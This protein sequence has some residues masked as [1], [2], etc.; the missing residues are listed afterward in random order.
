MPRVTLHTSS[1]VKR[2]KV[3]V[4]RW[5]NDLDDSSGHHL[6]GAWAYWGGL[7]HSWKTKSV[8]ARLNALLIRNI[9]FSASESSQHLWIY[10]IM[11]LYKFKYYYYYYYYYQCPSLFWHYCL[12]DRKCI[13]IVKHTAQSPEFLLWSNKNNSP[14]KRKTEVSQPVS[15]CVITVC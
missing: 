13:W 12:D 6:L 1:K 3:T 14:A 11:V 10:E 4:T 8:M 7:P 15:R 2:S 5:I 9:V